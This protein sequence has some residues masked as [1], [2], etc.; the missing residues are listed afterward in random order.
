LFVLLLLLLLLLLLQLSLQFS[1]LHMENQNVCQVSELGM[2][3]VCAAASGPA[4]INKRGEEGGRVCPPARRSLPPALMLRPLSHFSA[5]RARI[6]HVY[7]AWRPFSSMSEGH[8]EIK[9]SDDYAGV[10]LDRFLRQSYPKL[11]L[12]LIYRLLR[13]QKV[14]YH[15]YVGFGEGMLRRGR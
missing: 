11:P 5:L 9:V 8:V 10:R 7:T 14:L 12:S 3:R 13:T 6:S 2:K 1:N 4:N 15:S